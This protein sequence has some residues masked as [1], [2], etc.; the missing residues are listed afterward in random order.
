MKVVSPRRSFRNFEEVERFANMD[1]EHGVDIFCT[2]EVGKKGRKPHDRLDFECRS[3]VSN[4]VKL[5]CCTMR[6]GVG[7]AVDIGGWTWTINTPGLRAGKVDSSTNWYALGTDV[8]GYQRWWLG[9]CIGIGSTAVSPNDFWLEKPLLHGT[10]VENLSVFSGQVSVGSTNLWTINPVLYRQGS[11]WGTN[12]Y[13]YHLC[14]ITSGAASGKVFPIFTN[15]STTLQFHNYAWT[16]PYVGFFNNDGI[17]DGDDFDI[18]TYGQITHGDTTINEPIALPA[19]DI[20]RMVTTRT[21]TNGQGANLTVYEFGICVYYY[22]QHIDDETLMN[23]TSFLIVRDVIPTGIT[24][25]DGEQL[26]LTYRI[27][28]EC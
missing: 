11:G 16:S 6:G 4:F 27:T 10:E 21:F 17:S 9:P 13:Q 3:F 15:G 28:V 23:G 8:G 26:T 22:V 25:P 18:L 24:I 19:S 1:D 14:K 7:E 20:S 2:I 12:D 5:L